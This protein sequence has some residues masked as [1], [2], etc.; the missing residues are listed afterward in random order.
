L[1]AADVCSHDGSGRSLQPLPL[2]AQVSEKEA[3][4]AVLKREVAA[5]KRDVA[6]QQA[7]LETFS[8]DLAQVG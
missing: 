5:C 8:Q 7:L 3:A 4:A 1:H 2:R 6:R